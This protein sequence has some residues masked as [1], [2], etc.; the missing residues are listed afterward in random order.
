MN[1]AVNNADSLLEAEII[2]Q[3]GKGHQTKT[4]LFDDIKEDVGLSRFHPRL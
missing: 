4:I 1:R 2:R 3:G